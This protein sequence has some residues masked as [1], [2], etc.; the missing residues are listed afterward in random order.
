M[1]FIKKLFKF[2]LYSA[3]AFCVLVA[4]LGLMKTDPS[5]YFGNHKTSFTDNAIFSC[6]KQVGHEDYSNWKMWIP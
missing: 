3:V 1:N 5:K 4:V 2:I 6:K